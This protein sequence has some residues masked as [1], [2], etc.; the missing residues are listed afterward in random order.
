MKKL[1]ILIVFTF[2]LAWCNI[3]TENSD[4]LSVVTS[5]MPIWSIVN[6]IWSWKVDVETLVPAWFSPHG[7]ELKPQQLISIDQ[8]DIIFSVGLESIDWFLTKRLW[9][10]DK[11][12]LISSWISLLDLNSLNKE[13]HEEEHHEEE[14]HEEE[15]NEEEH[16]HWSIDPHVWLGIDESKYIAKL[17]TE[18]LSKKDPENKNYYNENLEKFIETIDQKVSLFKE[19]IKWKKSN[20]FLISH[21]PYNYLLIDLWIDLEKK[22]VFQ[23]NILKQVWVDD[24]KNI[25]DIIKNDGIKII[26][27]EPQ[28]ESKWLIDLANK[29]NMTI[30]NVD[31]LWTNNNYNEYFN[32]LDNNL[33][34][35]SK[36][37]E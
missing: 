22:V 7:Y 26:F 37:Y 14:H 5:I 1:F 29:Y 30:L 12:T 10:S 11:N 24:Y 23:K 25:T 13:H 6:Y 36:I 34:S 20:K 32:T 2:S 16:N 15:H 9:E 21:N 27:K 28:F 33:N 18:E 17:I 19:K 4:K 3:K 35:F 8:S 31:P